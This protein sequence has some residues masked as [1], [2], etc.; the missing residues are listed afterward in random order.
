[1]PA[2][3]VR[4]VISGLISVLPSGSVEGETLLPVAWFT[5]AS[6]RVTGVTQRARALPGNRNAGTL[7]GETLTRKGMVELNRIE[8]STS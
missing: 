5:G 3:V 6:A 7:P 4:R 2:N 8:L 1:M